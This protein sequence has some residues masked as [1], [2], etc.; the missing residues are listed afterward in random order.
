MGLLGKLIP[1]KDYEHEGVHHV[2]ITDEAFEE[3]VEIIKNLTQEQKQDFINEIVDMAIN[4]IA[5]CVK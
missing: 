1:E 3:A 2:R 5:A 4:K